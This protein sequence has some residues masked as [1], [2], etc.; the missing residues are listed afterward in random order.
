MAIAITP[1]GTT[2]YVANHGDG[3][4]TPLRLAPPAL[5]AD[6]PLLPDAPITVGKHPWAIAITRDGKTAYVANY[7]DGTITPVNLASGVPAPPIAAGKRPW[8][9]AIIG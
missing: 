2:A 3:T 5:A 8:A 7:G 1:D 9:I 6:H 4:V